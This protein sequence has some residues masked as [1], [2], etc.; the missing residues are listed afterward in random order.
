MPVGARIRHYRLER[1][2]TQAV[3]AAHTGIHVNTIARIERSAHRNL[4][5]STLLAFAR[6]FAVPLEALLT[7]EDTHA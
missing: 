3:L 4:R 1:Q 2:W 7:E 5:S 6:A